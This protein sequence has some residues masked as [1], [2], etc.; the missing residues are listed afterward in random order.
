MLEGA[1]FVTA[2]SRTRA[3]AQAAFT[4]QGLWRQAVWGCIAAAA[5]LLAVLAAFTDI[6][7]QRA[8]LVF[9][10]SNATPAPHPQTAQTSQVVAQATT[11]APS[12]SLDAD[13]V[14][15][16]L[17][18][19]VRGLADDRDRMMKRLAAIERNVDDMTGSISQQIE[20]VKAAS[21]PPAVPWLNT[22]SMAPI[23][24]PETS[25]PAG[26]EST[27]RPSSTPP[28]DAQPPPDAATT[29]ANAAYGAEIG[30]A[31]SI[32]AL[33]ARWAGIR[34]AH[35]QILDGLTPVVALRENPRS[36][37]TELRLVVGP[38]ANAAA[39]AQLCASLTA[40]RLSCF[41]TMFDGHNL[42]L[43]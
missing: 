3:G 15:R 17:T 14:I 26:W 21:T 20:A 13:Y 43:E 18:Q 1:R 41:P 8:A 12:R 24:A 29:P 19:T 2:T 33:H 4:M 39:A 22:A 37:K 6:G 11:P 38:F 7:S 42:A 27:P 9:G 35:L 32:K 28:T 40:V 10:A 36:H 34:S 31:A 5:V 16:Q 30:S 25:P 23:A